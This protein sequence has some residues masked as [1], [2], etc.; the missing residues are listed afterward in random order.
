L[1]GSCGP[2]ESL[3]DEADRPAEP[4]IEEWP[5]RDLRVGPALR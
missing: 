1:K 5:S 4:T 2:Q 3:Q